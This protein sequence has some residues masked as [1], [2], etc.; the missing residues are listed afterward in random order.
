MLEWRAAREGGR[1]HVVLV[2]E[3]GA[4]QT[5][6]FGELLRDASVRA[7]GLREAGLK[8]GETVAL[9][10]P[11]GRDY[12]CSFF[13]VLLAGGVPVPIYPPSRLAQVDEHVRRHA[14]ILANAGSRLLVTIPEAS[15]VALRLRAAAPCLARVVSANE[16]AGE[17]CS[18]AAAAGDLAL[19]QYTS[20]S[21]ADPKG[22]M[23]THANLLANLRAMGSVCRVSAEDCF[24]SWLPLYHD[25]G[26]IGAWFGALYFGFP[27]VLMSPLS[28]LAH[29]ARWLAAISRHRGTISAAPN[30]AYALCARKVSDAERAGLDLS[31]WRLALNGAEPVS[32]AVLDAFAARFAP[33]GLRR[34]ALSPVYGLAEDSVGL[35]FPAPGRGPKVDR[36]DAGR[37]TREGLAIAASGSLPA[38][39]IVACGSPLP[40]HELRIVDALGDE[41]ARSAGGGVSSFADLRRVRVISTIR[42]PTRACSAMA[43]WIAATWPIS[44]MATSTSLGASRT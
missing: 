5:L 4:E 30:F 19:L 14:K 24:V 7:G 25:M 36:I 20:G 34:E 37:F 2:T 9:M 32:S 13:G 8:P 43:G 44:P 16:L 10:L 6:S 21:T 42:R 11:T 15:A 31:C 27:L 28:F 29:P 22:V 3:S 18:W 1:T 12:L 17:P 39:E 41:T 26:L 33:A 40:G 38:L 35:T 23:L